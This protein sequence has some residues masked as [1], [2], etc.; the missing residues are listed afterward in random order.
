MWRFT[1]FMALFFMILNCIVVLCIDQ[2]LYYFLPWNTDMSAAL[3]HAAGLIIMSL[4]SYMGV[5][6]LVNKYL[7]LSKK[8]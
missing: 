7:P 3:L 8:A 5:V 2:P 6:H 4:L 1:L